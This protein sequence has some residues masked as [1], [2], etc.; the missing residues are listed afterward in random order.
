MRW[1]L[2]GT[3]GQLGKSL[4]S[5]LSSMTGH[6][7]VLATGHAELDIADETAVAGL[8][9]GLAGGPPDVLVN[10][11][12]FTAVD[13]CEG[14]EALAFRVNAHAPGLL[15]E[16]CARQ[17]V[18]LVHVS[19][20]YVF[21]GTASEPYRETMPTGPRTAYG[22]SKLAGERRVLDPLP[23]AI[24]VRTSWVYGAGRNFV[25]AILNQAELRRSGEVEGPLRV[26]DD[27]YGSPTYAGDLS[28]CIIELVDLSCRLDDAPSGLFHF[29]NAGVITWWD[30]ARAI[31]D[32]CGY[33]DLSIDA[34]QSDALDVP[35]ER[36]HY[37]VLDCSRVEQLGIRRRP[38][39]EGLADHLELAAGAPL[40]SGGEATAAVA[41]AK[42]A[43]L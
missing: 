1:A 37:S 34:I 2:T 36:P 26:V 28:R 38:W 19:T 5:M 18:R 17:A 21:D 43:S 8:F 23:E 10:A 22:R 6:E 42:R 11:A 35:A 12:A 39:Q 20:D 14:E 24:V 9:D 41:P 13:R 40:R 33:A 7:L 31:L 16:L 27:Q 15:A 29:S 4:A 30:F 25:A 32:A 3:G